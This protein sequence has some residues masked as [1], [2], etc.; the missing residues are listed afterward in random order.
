MSN[1]KK[2]TNNNVATNYSIEEDAVVISNPQGGVSQ[3]SVSITLSTKAL[4]ADAFIKLEETYDFGT[5]VTDGEA[6]VRRSQMV[7]ILRDQAIE[8]AKAVVDVVR[9]EIAKTPKGSVSVHPVN[10]VSVSGAQAGSVAPAFSGPQATVAVAN[11]AAPAS[12]GGAQWMSVPSKFGDGELRFIT[13]AT[14]STSQLEGEV[15]NW[16]R[17]HGLNPDAF[18][19]WDNR[20]GQKGLEAGVPNGCVA[21]VKIAKDAQSFVQGDIANQAIARVKFNSNGSLYIWLTKE[22]DAA[23]KYGALNGVKLEA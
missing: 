6:I 17:Q 4:G 19:V 3:V 14:Y 21:A 16:L 22:A 23:L 13:T 7:E 2:A 10:P 12:A 9:E 5:A 1:N 20:P 15:G 18:K 8:E 11:G